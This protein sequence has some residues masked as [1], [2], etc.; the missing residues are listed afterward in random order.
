MELLV[1]IVNDFKLKTIVNWFLDVSQVTCSQYA[2]DF[3]K[4]NISY[5]QQKT[6]IMVFWNVGSDY[7][8]GI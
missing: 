3:N 5:K 2:S 7:L 1:K 8:A 4:V 6:F